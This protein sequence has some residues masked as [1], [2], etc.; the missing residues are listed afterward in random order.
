[1][2]IEIKVDKETVKRM[3][4]PFIVTI[5]LIFSLIIFYN[6]LRV[7][8]NYPIVF[9][10]EGFHMK[11]AKEMTLRKEFIHFYYFF[12]P[13]HQASGY[14]TTFHFIEAFGF[15]ISEYFARFLLP[16]SIFL[17]AFSVFA[18][19]WKLFDEKIALLSAILVQVFQSTV[20]YSTTFY[21]DNLF[22]LYNFLAFSF[23]FIFAREKNLRYLLL[24]SVF[25]S[26]LFFS[27]PMLNVVAAFSIFF[28]VL[29]YLYLKV[30]NYKQ[31]VL[32]FVFPLMFFSSIILMN[33]SIYNK[34]CYNYWYISEIIN[35]ILK[36]SGECIIRTTDYVDK[37]SYKDFSDVTERVGSEQTLFDFGLLNYISFAY[38]NSLFIVFTLFTSICY[39]LFKMRRYD[40]LFPSI[41]II[42][43]TI[44]WLSTFYIFFG[45]LGIFGRTE[46]AARYTYIFN[47]FLALYISLFIYFIK[48]ICNIFSRKIDFTLLFNLSFFVLVFFVILI[49]YPLYS[50]KLEIM[51]RVKSFSSKFFEACDWVKNNINSTETLYSLWGQRVSYNCER[52]MV[53]V[54]D[55]R[56]SRNATEIY[57]ISKKIGL[58]YFFIE[59]FSIDP[60]N[61]NFAEMYDLDWVK[62]LLEN[63]Q[64]FEKV[65]ENGVEINSCI[66]N[67]LPRGLVCDGV[68]I[69]RVV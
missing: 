13:N 62:I 31:L 43:L 68:I 65:Y 47:P 28:L 32:Y 41:P 18:L 16:F 14:L 23:L 8:L 25:F 34:I 7:V 20:I 57:E 26:L 45:D 54:L 42:S 61:R 10:D 40:I 2:E 56:F 49:F 27:K 52:K 50:E 46:D 11:I 15:L 1:M 33:V 4:K 39:I 9:G 6:N 51:K 58:N 24:S 69:L 44:V 5:F 3:Y 48:D 30:I 37:Y 35:K 66:N 17:I 12:G 19:F 22:L 36:L 67:Y 38:G 21:V 59:K 63:P 64:Y 29:Y 53:G 55:L 60:L